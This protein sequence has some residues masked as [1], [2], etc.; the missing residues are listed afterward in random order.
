[1]TLPQQL[2]GLGS[3]KIGTRS[4]VFEC[5]GQYDCVI[6]VDEEDPSYKQEQMPMY[7]T[8]QVLLARSKI[9]GFDIA[10]VG[11]SP[12]VELMARRAKARSN[13]IEEPAARLAAVRLVDLSNYKF[14]PGLISP[15]VRDAIG[16]SLESRPKEHSGFKPQRVIPFDPLC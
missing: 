13:L 4:S 10:F 14:I 1:M 7:D 8:R 12:S 2:K 16:V 9:Y 15:P 5:D 11:I 3:V 6:M